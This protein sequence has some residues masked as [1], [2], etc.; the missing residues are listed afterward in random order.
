MSSTDAPDPA[1]EG[2]ESPADLSPSALAALD[3]R[4]EEAIADKD[5]FRVARLTTERG[6]FIDALTRASIDDAW[7]NEE[8][9]Q[10]LI[11]HKAL[12]H[13]MVELRDQRSQG[14]GDCS[15][16]AHVI[17]AYTGSMKENV[18]SKD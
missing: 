3:A 14:L 8:V 9:Q 6:V 5:D 18:S 11:R 15:R 7:S 17:Q 10:A 13:A 4:L 2:L 12:A 1:I 16:N